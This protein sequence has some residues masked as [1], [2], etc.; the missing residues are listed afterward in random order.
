MAALWVSWDLFSKAFFIAYRIASWR[1][2]VV[3]EM[4]AIPVQNAV[5]VTPRV[6]KLSRRAPD[7][8]HSRDEIIY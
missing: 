2:F 8:H 4:A 1:P 6:S 3:S 5:D 7:A